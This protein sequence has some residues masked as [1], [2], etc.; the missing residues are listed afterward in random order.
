MTVAAGDVIKVTVTASSKTAGTAV[1][2]NVTT[3]K[4][5]TKTFSNEASLGSL[6]E[7]NAEWIVE[8]FDEN[9]SEVTFADFGTVT[10]TGASYVHSGTTS[11]VSAATII[12]IEQNKVLTSCSVPSSSEVTCTYV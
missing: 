2:E 5:V 8:D 9:G 7:Y 11:G 10:F 3:G 1:L 4:T 12:D 6:C